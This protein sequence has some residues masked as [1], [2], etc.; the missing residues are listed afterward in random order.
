M[1]IL[2]RIVAS[3]CTHSCA[4]GPW[5][6]SSTV[7]LSSVYF[8]TLRV[9]AGKTPHARCR[10]VRFLCRSRSRGSI[11]QGSSSRANMSIY[12]VG[13]HSPFMNVRTGVQP[14][15]SANTWHSR[16]FGVPQS[17]CFHPSRIAFVYISAS[18]E[19]QLTYIAQAIRDCRVIVEL[20]PTPYDE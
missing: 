3:P 19:A 20:M 11:A 1:H 9:C 7:L 15:F 17:A 16:L 8:K 13:P 14:G 12:G 18:V 2:L 10:H 4:L 6:R 5:S